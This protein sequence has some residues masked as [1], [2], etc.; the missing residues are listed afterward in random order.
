[1]VWRRK[2]GALSAVAHGMKARFGGSARTATSNG[3]SH[4]SSKV[5]A[6]FL[7]FP[8]YAIAE[9]VKE[10]EEFMKMHWALLIVGAL[11]LWMMVSMALHSGGEKK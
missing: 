3:A 4:E 7:I 11:G 2:V 6:L 9:F 8:M 10:P 5:R 1:M